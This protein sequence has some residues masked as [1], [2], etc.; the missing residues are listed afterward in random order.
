MEEFEVSVGVDPS[1]K[2]TYKPLKKFQQTTGMI[3]KAM[4]FVHHQQI[5]VKNTKTVPVK[6][7]VIDQCPMSSN[8]KIKV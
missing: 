3:S 6:I 1:V 4:V 5:D 7:T 8:E 2:V